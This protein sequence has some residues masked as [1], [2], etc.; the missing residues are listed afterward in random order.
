MQYT[1]SNPSILQ[2][3]LLHFE[4]C[5]LL[6]DA[7]ELCAASRLVE[8]WDLSRRLCK[9]F[10]HPAA[11]GNP[12][13]EGSEEDVYTSAG[14]PPFSINNS[15]RKVLLVTY[16]AGKVFEE[17]QQKFHESLDVA[18]I[19]EHWR[20]NRSSFESG[21]HGDWYK[22]HENVNFARGGAW[23]PYIIWQAFRRVNWGE[24][25][26]TGHFFFSLFL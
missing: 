13:P 23:K 11:L 10:G 16:A 17:T 19:A 21:V 7:D 24:W 1:R 6:C 8:G 20:W 15:I 25:I 22:E 3:F 4:E 2:A 26:V 18:E 14:R 12:T 5:K 9:V